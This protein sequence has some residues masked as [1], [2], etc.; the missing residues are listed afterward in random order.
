MVNKKNG[1]L[2]GIKTNFTTF[3]FFKEKVWFIVKHYALPK[4][5]ILVL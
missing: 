4:Q 1:T 5:V 2:K 3:R